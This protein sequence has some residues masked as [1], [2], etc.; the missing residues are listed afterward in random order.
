[1]ELQGS[2]LCKEVACGETLKKAAAWEQVSHNDVVLTDVGQLFIS[3]PKSVPIGVQA[4]T[5]HTCFLL[6]VDLTYW[7][8]SGY[9]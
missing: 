8:D 6:L 9:H 7:L 1:M 4:D 2:S 3:L 5:V